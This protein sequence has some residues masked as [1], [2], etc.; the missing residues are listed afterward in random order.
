MWVCSWVSINMHLI[1]MKFK[2]LVHNIFCCLL[3]VPDGLFNGNIGAKNNTFQ[4]LLK[5]RTRKKTQTRKIK[6]L[7]KTLELAALTHPTVSTHAIDCP[8]G[9]ITDPMQPGPLR[10]LPAHNTATPRHTLPAT[11]CILSAHTTF[12]LQLP[13]FT[14]DTVDRS[15][16]HTADRSPHINGHQECLRRSV[17]SS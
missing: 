13:D 16:H 14:H 17:P 5:V 10:A 2:K 4:G 9:K 15:T 3:P 1:I 7:F 11:P 12:C 8:C 6:N